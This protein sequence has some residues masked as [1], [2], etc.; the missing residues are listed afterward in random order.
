MTDAARWEAV[1]DGLSE[2]LGA[3]IVQG[4]YPPGA[5]LY[6]G[7]IADEQHVSRS[8]V[9]E[10]VRVLETLGLVRVRRKA[11]IEVQPS[12]EWSHYSPDVIR[13]RLAGPARL[14]QLHELS[15]LRSAAEPLAARLAAVAA[16]DAERQALAQAAHDMALHS[17]RANERD[18]LDADIRFHRALL[19]ASGNPMLAGLAGAIESVLIGRTEHALM[20]DEANPAALRLHRELA[21]AVATRDADGASVAANQIVKEAD[22]AVQ[23]LDD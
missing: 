14:Q 13:W 12:S 17:H 9:R 5:R 1:H 7:D 21:F 18:Y 19:E 23:T 11:G 6:S 20:P 4:R 16:T 2:Q 8:A 3:A 10:V 22:D 15:Q